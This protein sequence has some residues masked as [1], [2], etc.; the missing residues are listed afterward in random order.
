MKIEFWINREKEEVDPTL[1]SKTAEELAT[2]LAEECSQSRMKLNKRT[3]LRKFYD[4]VVRLDTAARSAETNWRTIL[5]L[6]HMLT[7][8]AAYAKGRELISDSFLA[9]VKDSVAQIRDTKDLRIF[10]TFF[11]AVM[12][13]YRQ[14]G[15]SN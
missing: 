7:A 2:Q 10:A 3:Q 12:G 4:E 13:F 11:E 6:V 15:P 5:P 8:K 9:F 1:F 14:L